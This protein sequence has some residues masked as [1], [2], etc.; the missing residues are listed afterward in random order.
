MNGEVARQSDAVRQNDLAR[1]RSCLLTWHFP[2]GD[3]LGPNEAEHLARHVNGSTPCWLCR[4]WLL[5]L[6]GSQAAALHSLRA[7]SEALVKAVLDNLLWRLG[8]VPTLGAVARRLGIDRRHLTGQ[9]L[10]RAQQVLVRLQPEFMEQAHQAGDAAVQQSRTP[11]WVSSAARED[12]LQAL[13]AAPALVQLVGAHGYGPPQHQRHQP[14]L[15]AQQL[16]E[17]QA[18][19]D[20]PMERVAA[21]ADRLNQLLGTGLTREQLGACRLSRGEQWWWETALAISSVE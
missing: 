17:Y 10:P 12:S 11:P 19:G 13:A 15:Q 5:D 16:H 7:Q 21:L 8:G 18:V 2:W 3:A 1:L 6:W 9:L 20:T 14:Q 4:W